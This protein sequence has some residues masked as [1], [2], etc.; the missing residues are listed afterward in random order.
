[1]DIYIYG[2]GCSAG[3]LIDS[4]LPAERISA[5]LSETGGGT[6]LG[7]PVIALQELAGRPCDLI[8]VADR[9]ADEAAARFA[10]LGID[11]EKL[12]FLKNH[13]ALLDRNRCYPLAKTVLGEAF[14]RSL[15]CSEHLIRSPLW[16]Q[17][18]PLPADALA[19]DYVRLKTLEALC[20]RVAE[21][22]GCAAELGVYRGDFARCINLL[23]PQKELYLFDT[24]TGFDAR[25][26]QSSGA[27]FVFAHRLT[28]AESVLSRMPHPRRIVVRQGL[29]PETA[30]GLEEKRFAFVSLDVD[31]E[32]STLHGL[33][34]FVPRMAQGGTLMLHD[35]ENPKLP[36]V[37]R[38]VERYEQ[39]AGVRLCGVPIPDI[40]GTLVLTF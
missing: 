21:I 24:F 18:E 14:V 27:G 30:A 4:V 38:A 39:E 28:D 29:F 25:E 12:L 20:R 36:G 10:A 15:Q 3:D 32:E 17:E 37:K 40:N 1:L 8:L 26:A 34:W 33:R 23:L 2:T 6:F 31:L 9:R 11:P 13:F 5:F 19:G 16:S 35:Y 22:P 7:R